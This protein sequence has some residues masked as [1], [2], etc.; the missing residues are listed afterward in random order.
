MLRRELGRITSN[1]MPFQG[2]VENA[3]VLNKRLLKIKRK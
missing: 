3:E 2:T 1:E